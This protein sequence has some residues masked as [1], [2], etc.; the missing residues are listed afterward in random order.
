MAEMTLVKTASGVLAPADP[1]TVA[2]I[3]KH[4]I[5]QAFKADV[6]RF[7]NL[8]FHRKFFALLNYGFDVWEPS[9]VTYKGEIVKKNFKRFRE[10]ITIL[11]GYFETSIGIDGA[12][13]I[14]AKSIRF[15]AMDQD[16][17]DG[18]FNAVIDV[19]LDRVFIGQTRGD[20]E[21]TVNNIM[22]FT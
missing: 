12:V 19:L 6:R 18:L 13:R 1:Q 7:R 3:Q 21:N 15:D 22:A 2:V 20:V 5:G 9:E 8:P 14:S 16:E 17:F 11:A 10:D 4:K